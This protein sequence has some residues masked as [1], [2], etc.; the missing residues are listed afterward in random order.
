MLASQRPKSTLIRRLI[1]LNGFNGFMEQLAPEQ[2]LVVHYEKDD[3]DVIE[4]LTS[5]EFFEKLV[6]QLDGGAI[7]GFYALP[8]DSQFDPYELLNRYHIDLLLEDRGSTVSRPTENLVFRAMTMGVR[9]VD[10]LN[11]E[12]QVIR[13]S[14]MEYDPE[15]MEGDL[16]S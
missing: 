2:Y 8:K 12:H 14:D 13:Q 7:L 11:W 5:E 1:S 4:S 3:G 9:A 15:Y 10:L 16:V 6:P